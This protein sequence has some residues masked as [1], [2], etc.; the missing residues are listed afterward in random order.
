MDMNEFI[1]IFKESLQI[2]D[3][4]IQPETKFKELPLWDSMSVMSV[5]AMSDEHF[6]KEIDVD[7]LNE[8]DTIEELYNFLTD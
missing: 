8:L 6:S 4:D 2:E 5:I 7:R 1:S 3:N